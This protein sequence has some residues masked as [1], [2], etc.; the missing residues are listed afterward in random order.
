MD[1][2]APS[3]SEL[4]CPVCQGRLE[5]RVARGRKS[6]KPFIMLICPAS[7]KHLRAFITDQTYVAGVL[8]RLEDQP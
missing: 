7:G 3:S 5:V 4:A 8:A 1:N 6:G 2:H